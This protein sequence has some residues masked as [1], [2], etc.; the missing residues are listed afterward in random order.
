[1]HPPKLHPEQH[2][3]EGIASFANR[4]SMSTRGR[5]S[6]HELDTTDE[7]QLE[8]QGFGFNIGALLI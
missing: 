4:R 2:A 6:E 7:P 1:M 3:K 8:I 5:N